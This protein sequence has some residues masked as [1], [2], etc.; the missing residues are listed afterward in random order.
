MSLRTAGALVEVE[1]G[2]VEAR[3][4]DIESWSAFLTEIRSL[5][6]VGH[7]RYQVH[8]ADGRTSLV[9]VGS[10]PAQHRYRWQS[11]RGPTFL[12][13]ISLAA[14]GGSHTLITLEIQLEPRGLVRLV[15]DMLA[16]PHDAIDLDMRGLVQHVASVR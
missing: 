12:G 11:L 1:L 13:Q 14:A 7:E 3:L 8:L 6:R 5:H 15:L 10:D 4:N 9:W 2:Q 16:Q